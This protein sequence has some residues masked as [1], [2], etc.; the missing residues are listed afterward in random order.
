MRE[1]FRQ[2]GGEALA[3]HEILE[4]L[5]FYSI[6]RINTNETAHRLIDHFGGLS[7]VLS[8]KRHELTAVPGVGAQSADLICLM[9][10]LYR[11][12][13]AEDSKTPRYFKDLDDVGRYLVKQLDGLARER[14]LLLLLTADYKLIATHQISEGSVNESSVDVRQIMEYAIMAKASHIVLAHNHPDPMLI[15]SQVDESVSISLMHAASIM[16]INLWEHVLVSDG[17]Y[18]FILREMLSRKPYSSLDKYTNKPKTG[19]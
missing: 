2:G 15:P 8:A 4:M 3:D 14:V 7:G 6:P 18:V 13:E 1:K 17:K 11:R 10:E 16:G 19:K 5:L 9:A 12:A